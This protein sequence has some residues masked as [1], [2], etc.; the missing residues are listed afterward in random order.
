MIGSRFIDWLRSL[1]AKSTTID[2]TEQLLIDSSGLPQRSLL[3]DLLR[4]GGGTDTRVTTI[5]NTN[6]HQRNDGAMWLEVTGQTIGNTR[7]AGAFDWQPIRTNATFVASGPNT[8]V[9]GVNCTA[10]EQYSTVFGWHGSARNKSMLA[11]GSA[12]ASGVG[13][14]VLQPFYTV[15][16]TNAL[17][18]INITGTATD[19]M[20][21]PAA[22]SISFIGLV[23]AMA[24]DSGTTYKVKAWEIKGVIMRDT[25]TATTTRIVGTPTI[26][27]LA[28]DSD[29]T[30]TPSTWSI[31][32]ITADTTNGSL[33]INFVGQN[34]V[35]IRV[36]ASLF[37][38][39]VGF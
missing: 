26:N 18:P 17:T 19:R 25:A 15:T 14:T 27:V 35:T 39:Q 21:I 8:F 31:T 4:Y 24:L 38:S 37:Y 29:G 3:S 23:T 33:S 32:G 11:I 5:G 10:T 30:A 16:T 20:V 2:G 36:Q 7:G 6:I 28:Q 9:Y 22:D 34:G 12:P 13:Q 1:T